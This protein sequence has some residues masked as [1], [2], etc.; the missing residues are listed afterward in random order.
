[1]KL[2]TYL[3]YDGR[4][5]DD[6][7]EAL[8]L[9]AVELASDAEAIVYFQENFSGQDA[10][11]VKTKEVKTP[12]GRT[13]IIKDVRPHLFYGLGQVNP[14]P[15]MTNP[16]GRHWAQP[17]M[18]QVSKWKFDAKT[19]EIPEEHIKFL[20]RYDSTLPSGVY[21]GKMWSRSEPDR[22]LLVWYGM[23]VQDSCTVEFREIKVVK[24][25]GAPQA[26]DKPSAD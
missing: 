20:A 8:V 7:D 16:M 25:E 15:E 13:A 17:S 22:F 21:A 1:M 10:Y 18:A 11:G 14:I 3:V 5:L 24:T 12:R 19:V 4:W 9:D 26:V 6:E 2:T 23:E